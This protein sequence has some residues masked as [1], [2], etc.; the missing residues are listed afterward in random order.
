LD[1][2]VGLDHLADVIG[3]VRAQI[4]TTVGQ[5]TDRH[6]VLADVIEDDRLRGIEIA[7]A[8]RIEDFPHHLQKLA[9]QPLDHADRAQILVNLQSRLL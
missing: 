4:V 7:H 2:I 3:R 6:I 8:F 1:E 9:M 5:F